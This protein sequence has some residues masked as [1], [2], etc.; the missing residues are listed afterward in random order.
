[1]AQDPFDVVTVTSYERGDKAFLRAGP[2]GKPVA[3]GR[4]LRDRRIQLGSD[5]GGDWR[6]PFTGR[7]IHIDLSPWEHSNPD[8]TMIVIK[9]RRP[10]QIRR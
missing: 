7:S 9:F 2:D 3:M 10:K 4:S 5:Q 8:M 1:M 6:H